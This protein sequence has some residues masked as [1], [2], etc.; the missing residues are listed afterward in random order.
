[1]IDFYKSMINIYRKFARTIQEDD[2]EEGACKLILKYLTT[3]RNNYDYIK[4]EDIRNAFYDKRDAENVKRILDGEKKFLER[5]ISIL[6]IYIKNLNRKDEYRE[7]YEAEEV[8][9]L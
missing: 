3:I 7:D 1:M 4:N 6:K 8:N 9:D 5:R 2:T